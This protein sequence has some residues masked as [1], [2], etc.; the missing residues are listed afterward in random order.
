MKM[1]NEVSKIVDCGGN[2]KKKDK[3]AALSAF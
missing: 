3:E 1:N 2:R